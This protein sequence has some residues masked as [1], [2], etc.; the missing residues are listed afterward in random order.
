MGEYL[1]PSIVLQLCPKYASTILQLNTQLEY[2]IILMNVPL[3]CFTYVVTTLL[4]YI[5]LFY[6][7]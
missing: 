4:D 2:F 5:D 3:G 6:H 1:N 7:T